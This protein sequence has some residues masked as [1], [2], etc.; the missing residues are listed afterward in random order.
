M[1]T[2]LIAGA[3]ASA[4][5]VAGAARADNPNIPSNS[6]YAIMGGDAPAYR[7]AWDAPDYRREYRPLRRW[8]YRAPN[9]I[10]D[11]GPPRGLMA[12]QPSTIGGYPIGY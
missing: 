3:V 9:Y 8:V 2:I 4:I 11:T 5:L 12:D 7:E 1:K 10:H 6:P